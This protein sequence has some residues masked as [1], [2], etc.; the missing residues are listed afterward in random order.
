MPSIVVNFALFQLGWFACVVGAA[1]AQPWAGTLSVVVIVAYHLS[2]AGRPLAEIKLIALALLIGF[3]W[4]ST[5]VASGLLVYKV[6][7]LN[8][9]IAPH[10]IIA[11]WALFASTLNVSL[12]WLKGH[13]LVAALFG[14]AGGP[15]AYYAGSRLGAVYLLD[16]FL[17]LLALALGWAFIMPLL[18]YLSDR[19]DGFERQQRK[20]EVCDA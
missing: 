6:G 5:L 15:L 1:Y 17:S 4:D 12:R 8:E 3:L 18:M 7:M 11:I 16:P 9:M 20:L 10:W 14:M 19:Y 2:R 13:Y